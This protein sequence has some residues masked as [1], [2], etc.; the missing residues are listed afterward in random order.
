MRVNEKSVVNPDVL[1]ENRHSIHSFLRN[2]YAAAK[3]QWMDGVTFF[4]DEFSSIR[5]MTGSYLNKMMLP[6]NN[7]LKD[8][9]E[10]ES[11]LQQEKSNRVTTGSAVIPVEIAA[12]ISNGE[13][14]Y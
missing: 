12:A 14:N 3:R 9:T 2:S 1:T 7:F 6:V 10:I 5:D 4:K 8:I 13:E 11:E